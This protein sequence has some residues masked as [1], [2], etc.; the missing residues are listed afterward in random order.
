MRIRFERRFK[1][2]RQ[3]ILNSTD[4]IAHVA[5]HSGDKNAR[6][7]RLSANGH[8]GERMVS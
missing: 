4:Q 5:W 2:R 1:D 7:P 8:N 6:Q 3:S